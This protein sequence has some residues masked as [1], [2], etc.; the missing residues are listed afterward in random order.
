M[1]NVN[2]LG[3][4]MPT[5]ALN[6]CRPGSEVVAQYFMFMALGRAGYTAMMQSLQEIAVHISSEIAKMGPYRLI[7]EGRDL[8]VFAFALAPE[9]R[10]T[11]SSTSPTGCASAA[12]WSPPTPSRRTARTSACCGSSS[13]PG[14]H[15]EMA[16]D[17]ARAPAEKT[18]ALE[19]LD[20]PLPAEVASR[21]R[22]FAH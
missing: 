6:F 20:A 10:T 22:A 18:K 13:A 8:P 14:M 16:D 7:S 1:F 17:A 3:G 5:F 9:V 2:Y 4:N 11:P 21:A 15:L 19:A 12:G